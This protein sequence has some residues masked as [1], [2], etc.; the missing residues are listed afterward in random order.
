MIT[1]EETFK[2]IFEASRHDQKTL[3][4]KALKLA[5]ESGEVAQAML[6]Y[7]NAPACGYKG[8]NK[9]NVIEECWDCI[10][11]AASIIFQVEDGK[12]DGEFSTDMRDK[13]LNK[14][15]AKSTTK[16]E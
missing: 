7:M 8:K 3:V 10:I 14:W 5:E 6:S 11:T 2:K 9:E 16:A 12:V 15:I 4:E 1:D 13:K